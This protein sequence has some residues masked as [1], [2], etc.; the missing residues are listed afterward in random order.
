[1]N[2]TPFVCPPCFLVM[3]DPSWQHVVTSQMIKKKEQGLCLIM[4]SILYFQDGRERDKLIVPLCFDCRCVASE[5]NL[6]M[7]HAQ[8]MNE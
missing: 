5:R 2:I 3:E 8:R 1:M 7:T 6:K 4:L